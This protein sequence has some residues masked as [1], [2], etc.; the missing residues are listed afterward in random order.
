MDKR[1]ELLQAAIARCQ[2]LAKEN[3]TGELVFD[4]ELSAILQLLIA[5]KAD[6]NAANGVSQ[7]LVGYSG[8]TVPD[9]P[10]ICAPYIP[11][12]EIS[13]DNAMIPTSLS[14]VQSLGHG[15]RG[16]MSME[17]TTDP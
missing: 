6:E 13:W 17:L 10:E 12:V 11:D 16:A 7:H 9:E 5:A 1:R 2:E 15:L 8:I 14:E 4:D 3:P